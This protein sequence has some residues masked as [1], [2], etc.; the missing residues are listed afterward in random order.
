MQKLLKD[1]ARR[2]GGDCYF[3]DNPD[4][5]PRLFAQDT[6]TVARS[7]FVDQPRRFN[8]PPVIHLLG[9]QPPAAPPQLG[10]YNLCYIRPQANLA[11]ATSDE[12]NAPGCRLMERR[13]WSRSLFH[14]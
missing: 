7:T 9:A 12:Y 4:E 11:A 1:I 13:Q 8:L 5:I 14:G 3:S 6:F 2:G 10:G